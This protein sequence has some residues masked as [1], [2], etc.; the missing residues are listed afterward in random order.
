MKS[1]I[2]KYLAYL[3]VFLM[4]II[5]LDVLW[6]VF[7]RYA[8]GSQAGW[9]E[10]LARYL[11]IW[12]GML[13][14]A[15]ASGQKMHLAIDLL[16]PKLSPQAQAKLSVFINILIAGF[17]LMAMV[18]GGL[19]L[20]YITHTLGQTS[21]AMRAPMALVYAAIPLAGA[22]VVFYKINALKGENQAT[23]NS[24]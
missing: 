11:L 18:I 13:G 24:V 9:T 21:A 23:A 1:T 19:R 12:I 6:G 10:E 17:A 2:D 4:A 3:L 5:T 8:L 15:Y 22:L 7:T 20:M 14:T 16:S